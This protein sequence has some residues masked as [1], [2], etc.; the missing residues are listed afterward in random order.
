LKKLP[1]ELEDDTHS[2]DSGGKNPIGGLFLPALFVRNGLMKKSK[3]QG[4]KVGFC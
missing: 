4:E 3:I 1:K 2:P